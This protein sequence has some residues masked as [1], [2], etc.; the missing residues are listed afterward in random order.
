MLSSFS[1]AD[2]GVHNTKICDWTFRWEVPKFVF[3][4]EVGNDQNQADLTASYCS[5]LGI[6]VYVVGVP[7]PFGQQKVKIKYVEFDP[8]YASD[9]QWAVIEQGPET[10]YPE[11]VR[12]RS[13]NAADEAI[14][15]G[16]GPFSLSKLCAATGGIYFCVHA[17]RNATG[18][19]NEG[20]RHDCEATGRGDAAHLRREAL[21]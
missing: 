21:D 12:V 7:A 16:F 14:D 18:R 17:N 8:K 11:V 19:V 4:D 9:V 6:P 3:T 20:T 13:G 5:K 2:F 10:L 15:S 1:A